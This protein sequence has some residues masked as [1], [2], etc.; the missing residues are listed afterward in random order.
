K[1]MHGP[2][3]D[4]GP[5]GLM[6]RAQ[7]GAVIAMEVLVEQDQVAPV[8]VLLELPALAVHR[9]PPILITQEDA[10]E[11]AR[12]LLS[13]LVQGHMLSRARRP[14]EGDRIA[15]VHVVLE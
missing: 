6:T 13:H 2:C 10:G 3:N 12:D 8:R 15:V 14:L 5:S 4:S 9:P 7:T 11:T 1:R